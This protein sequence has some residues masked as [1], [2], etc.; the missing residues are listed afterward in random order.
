MKTIWQNENGNWCR[1]CPRCHNDVIHSSKHTAKRAYEKSSMCEDCRNKTWNDTL[2]KPSGEHASCWKGYGKIP[3][4]YFT[5]TRDSAIKRHIKFEVSIQ[6]MSEVFNKQNGK[7]VLSGVGL[8]FGAKKQWTASIDRKDS[9][10]GYSK[11]NIQ[12]VHKD[13]N[14]MKSD[15]TDDRFIELCRQVSDNVE[16]PIDVFIKENR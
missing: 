5:K 1:E 14:Q 10:K 3:H 4:S 6:D 7:C 13:I 12:W 11:D 15:R 8:S 16:T 9:S 2:E